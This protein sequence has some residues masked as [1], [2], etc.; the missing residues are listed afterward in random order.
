MSHP[1]PIERLIADRKART[2][3]LIEAFGRDIDAAM[4]RDV[5]DII[6]ARAREMLAGRL[7]FSFCSVAAKIAMEMKEEAA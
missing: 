6:M 3:T 1:D 7:P 5:S 2:D 4:Q